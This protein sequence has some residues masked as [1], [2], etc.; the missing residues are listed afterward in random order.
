MRYFR[1]ERVYIEKSA[2]EDRLTGEILSRLPGIPREIVEDAAGVISETRSESDPFTSGK[3]KLL[4]RRKKGD[5][6]KPFPLI[7]EYLSCHFQ[8]LHLGTGCDLECT[9]CILQSYLTNPLITVF[10]NFDD[11]L[12]ELAGR[13]DAAPGQFFRVGTGE[14]IDSLSLDHLTEWSVPLVRFFAGREN[15]VLEFKTKSDNV[16]NLG[17]AD[18]RG[19]VIVSWSMNTEEIQRREEFKTA[20]LEERVAAAR[21]CERWGYRTGFHLD[22]LIHAEGWKNGYRKTVDLIFRNL[23]PSRIAWISLGALRFMPSLKKTAENRFGRT[24]IF[25]GEFI[26]GLDGKKRYFKPIRRKMYEYVCG[27][28]REYS[29]EVPVYLCMESRELWEDSLEVA[30]DD[31]VHLKGYLDQAAIRNTPSNFRNSGTCSTNRS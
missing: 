29:A 7:P 3:K 17:K 6:L 18:P 2:L 8:I 28:I 22:P 20:T 13:L 16:Q 30:L 5:F 10:T 4:L 1:P 11:I 12:A 31:S 21:K 27:L 15:A 23:N 14:L 24:G 9:Y 19:R 25:A 26:P